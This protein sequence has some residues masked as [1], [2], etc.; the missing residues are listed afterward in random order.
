M[1]WHITRNPKPIPTRAHDYDFWDNDF[2]GT[3]GL[4]GTAESIADAQRQIE[5]MESQLT[6]MEGFVMSKWKLVP[7][8]CPLCVGS[9]QHAQVASTAAFQVCGECH[10][11]G[12]LYPPAWREAAPQPPDA[13]VKS[14]WW[15]VAEIRRERIVELEAIIER[16]SS[17]IST[18]DSELYGNQ[19]YAIEIALF[20]TTLKP[21]EG[22]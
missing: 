8:L 6:E 5:E 14:G 11:R 10:G 1:T 9:G 13:S 15:D 3:N 20:P 4:C 16:V 19:I 22:E 2:D 12:V 21:K 18:W 17:V 7:V